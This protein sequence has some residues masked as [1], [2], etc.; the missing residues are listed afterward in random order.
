MGAEGI[1]VALFA[2]PL[3]ALS[4]SETTTKRGLTAAGDLASTFEWP[5]EQSHPGSSHRAP[6]LRLINGTAA[7]DRSHHFDVFDLVR[8]HGVKVLREDYVVGEFAGD[9]RALE[10]FLVGG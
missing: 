1:A 5:V 7:G 2:R 8:S 9:D 10:V 6:A 4:K 3:G